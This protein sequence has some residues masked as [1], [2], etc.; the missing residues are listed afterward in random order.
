MIS[1]PHLR[2]F[3]AVA[4]LMSFTRAA[5][6]LSLSQ[7]AVSAH[8]AALEEALGVRLF[9]R[10][11]RRI[12]L[13]DA[14]RIVYRAAQDISDRMR[15]LESELEDLGELRSGVIRIGASRI[16]GVYLLPRIITSF[17]E[18]F[19]D[20]EIHVTNHTAH[21]IARLVEDNAFDLAVV[22][23]GDAEQ[24][25]TAAVG[26]KRIGTDDL[27]L[28]APNGRTVSSL[29]V[30]RP[31]DVLSPEEV[32]SE[33][34]I[35]SGPDTASARNLRR[36][37]ANLGLHLKSTIVMD[38]AGAIKRTV[39]EG[40]GLAILSRSAVERELAEGRLVEVT[41]PGWS[42]SRGIFM[43]WRNDRRFSRNTEVFMEFLKNRLSEKG[44]G[45]ADIPVP[46]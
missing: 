23:E 7:P 16:A 6:E 37:L 42:L 12:V 34:F 43:L 8:V 25:P 19:P 9:E 31:G 10:T 46:N 17:R 41:V 45:A 13:T 15:Q 11:G 33:S 1:L 40:A 30:F 28:V 29:K 39:E 36:Q 4:R 38:D 26:M 44:N 21:T 22:C 35:L 3:M 18:R 27:V 32:Q 5:Y 14:G 24:Y 20:I 2:T